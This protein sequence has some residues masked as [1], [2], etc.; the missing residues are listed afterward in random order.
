M[1]KFNRPSLV[2]FYC[3]C[4]R[5]PH[6]ASANTNCSTDT[7]H[8]DNNKDNNISYLWIPIRRGRGRSLFTRGGRGLPRGG[9]NVMD[10]ASAPA[11][12]REGSPIT[13]RL[14]TTSY[15][16]SATDD[17]LALFLHVMAMQP[18]HHSITVSPEHVIK[19]LWR[20]HTPDLLSSISY[21]SHNIHPCFPLRGTAA[22][23][24]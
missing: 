11:T 23:V 4:T 16:N 24:K 7:R 9:R 20:P 21:H 12:P 13:Y 5:S 15:T 10:P 1:Q 6:T 18:T 8:I 14:T 17:K 3:F 19:L 2:V 22:L